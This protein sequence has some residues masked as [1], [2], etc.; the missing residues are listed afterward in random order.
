M[1]VYVRLHFQ[2][3]SERPYEYQVHCHSPVRPFSPE[4]LL[5]AMGLTGEEPASLADAIRAGRYV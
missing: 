2:G 1:P 5:A 4:P 3:I